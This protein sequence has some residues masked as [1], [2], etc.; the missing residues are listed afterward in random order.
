MEFS[1]LTN[2][3]HDIVDDLHVPFVQCQVYKE[4]K[5]VYCHG[6]G[7]AQKDTLVTPEHTYN[8]YSTTKFITCT[9]ALQL[10]EQGKYLMTEPL[11]EYFPQF[12]EMFVK[13][14]VC[15]FEKK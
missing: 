3:L 7:D 4:G 2:L 5:E 12:K 8:L 6:Y 1:N 14:A 15:I 11:Y 9:A 13:M 10:L